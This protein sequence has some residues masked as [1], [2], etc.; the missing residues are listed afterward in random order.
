MLFVAGIYIT[1]PRDED[2]FMAAMQRA[3]Y[4]QDWLE[5]VSERDDSFFLH[6]GDRA[7]Q[8]L[9]EQSIPAFRQ[10]ESLSLQARMTRYLDETSNVDGAWELD[11]TVFAGRRLVAAAAWNNLCAATLIVHRQYD[12]FGDPSNS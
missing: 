6:E 3:D 4:P 11:E 5:F 1:H 9:R 2:Q 10:A 7:C 12:P 8:W